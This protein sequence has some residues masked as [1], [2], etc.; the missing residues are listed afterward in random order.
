VES[1]LS[2]VSLVV[3]VVTA[4]VGVVYAKITQLDDAYVIALGAIGE[5]TRPAQGG[6]FGLLITKLGDREE[7]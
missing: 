1:A 4:V 2:L 3:G 7:T 6:P 5:S